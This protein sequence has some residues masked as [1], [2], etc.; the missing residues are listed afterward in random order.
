M[1]NNKEINACCIPEMAGRIKDFVPPPFQRRLF[2][3]IEKSIL[4][5]LYLKK[6][7]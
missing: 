3:R 4:T 2:Q 6:L 1:N 7:K 5:L